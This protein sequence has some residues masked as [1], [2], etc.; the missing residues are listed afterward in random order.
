MTAP[1]GLAS[2]GASASG[3]VRSPSTCGD[4]ATERLVEMRR[5]QAVASGTSAAVRKTER[6]VK[7]AMSVVGRAALDPLLDDR[8]RFGAGG[9]RRGGGLPAAE[10]RV[11]GGEA[12][13]GQK[14][15]AVRIAR[16]DQ[17]EPARRAQPVGGGR[18][19]EHPVGMPGE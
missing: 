6:R 3:T 19:H 13:L 9:A 7:G 11:V 2:S 14:E 4:T 18:V 16:L 12:K 17:R 10:L 1:P 5:A 15:A 8:E